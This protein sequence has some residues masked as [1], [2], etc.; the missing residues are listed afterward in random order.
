VTAEPAPPFTE[1]EIVRYARGVITNE[2]LVANVNDHDWQF[3]MSLLLCAW[4]KD[5]IPPNLS[6]CFLV[7]LAPHANGRWLNGR[8]PGV[9]ISAIAV[10]ME[11][12]DM[13]ND[14]IQEMWAMLNP[15][16]T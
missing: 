12:V 11:S 15:D 6:T 3:S 14:K 7:P 4:D 2:Y 10:P 13:L 16:T 8:V 1:A 9:T 5:D